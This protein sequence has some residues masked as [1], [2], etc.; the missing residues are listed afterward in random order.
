M[1]LCN[2]VSPGSAVLVGLLQR[3]TFAMLPVVSP[4][5]DGFRRHD[6]STAALLT[7]ASRPESNAIACKTLESQARRLHADAQDG[8]YVARGVQTTR[9]FSLMRVWRQ[10][11][12]QPS[13]RWKRSAKRS[14]D[15]AAMEYLSALLCFRQAPPP[16]TGSSRQAAG[17]RRRGSPRRSHRAAA[18]RRTTRRRHR[19]GSSHGRMMMRPAAFRDRQTR[20]RRRFR[21]SRPPRRR[22]RRRRASRSDGTGANGIIDARLHPRLRLRPRPR[23]QHLRGA[24]SSPRPPRRP[25]SHNRRPA[26]PKGG[27]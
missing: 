5:R 9:R 25:A 21:Q 22:R 17:N 11:A 18:G 14:A 23:L 6:C 20:R 4:L 8:S 10:S 12:V 27:R 15:I 26:S 2:L 16:R 24:A 1:Q 7:H 13:Q 19:N 3:R